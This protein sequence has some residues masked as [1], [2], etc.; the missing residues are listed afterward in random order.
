M[1]RLLTAAIF[2]AALFGCTSPQ[3]YASPYAA[4]RAAVRLLDTSA[5]NGSGVVIAPGLVLTA[6]HAAVEVE[7][8]LLAEPGAKPLKVLKIDKTLDL[9]VLQADVKCPCAKIADSPAAVDE[10]VIVIG[11]PHA[12]AVKH[13]IVTQ[14]RAQGVSD[15]NLN[16]TAPV[17]GGN[18]G[19]G[20]FVYRSGE[21]QLV[22]VLI[23]TR[24]G[25]VE[26]PGPRYAAS[27]VLSVAVD[28]ATVRGFLKGVA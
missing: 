5:G 4:P 23:A 16:L 2:L 18:S 20:V 7:N 9:A 26:S 24:A 21:W 19:G 1:K 12:S 22:G 8:G 13:E 25:A 14:G 27:I 10:P 15:H 3:E 28:L 6:A 17:A 11:Y